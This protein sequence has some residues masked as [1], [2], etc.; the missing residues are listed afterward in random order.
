MVAISK[1]DQSEFNE[2][3]HALCALVLKVEEPE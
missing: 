3:I 1:R 2:E